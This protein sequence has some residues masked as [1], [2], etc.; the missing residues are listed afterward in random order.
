MERGEEKGPGS[1]ERRGRGKG[2]GE[3]KKKGRR[4]RERFGTLTLLTPVL[5]TY[6]EEV[7]R[8]IFC[9]LSQSH[10]H[11]FWWKRFVAGGGMLTFR[12]SC[13][14]LA[15]SCVLVGCSDCK[16]STQEFAAL[17]PEVFDQQ[18]SPSPGQSVALIT[19]Q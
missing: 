9:S 18:N 7:E 6:W 5:N 16:L 1:R 15:V 4:E 19:A 10:S 2:E 3:G 17:P 11:A 13:I 8:T 14:Y 12:V